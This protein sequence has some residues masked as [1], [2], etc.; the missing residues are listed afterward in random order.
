M[1]TQSDLNNAIISNNYELCKELIDNGAD[2]NKKLFNT[3]TP[4][5][6]A[7]AYNG[8]RPD[9]VPLCKLDI[10]KLFLDSGATDNKDELLLQAVKDNNKECSKLLLEYGASF[11]KENLL[12]EVIN[13][14]V[15]QYQQTKTIVDSALASKL[16]ICQ[17]LVQYGAD[18]SKGNPLRLAIKSMKIVIDDEDRREF[19][20]VILEAVERNYVE[21]CKLLIENGA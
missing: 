18:V 9:G 2:I 17:L 12:C 5:S 8:T 14:N 21:I 4:L 10:C 16:E 11:D 6:K 13:N 19:D 7:V 3:N 20:P 1:S 15:F